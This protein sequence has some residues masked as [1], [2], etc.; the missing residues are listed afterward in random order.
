MLRQIAGVVIAVMGAVAL[1]PVM[2]LTRRTVLGYAYLGFWG[3]ITGVVLV[4]ILLTVTLAGVVSLSRGYRRLVKQRHDSSG[5]IG[6]V[7]E[8]A[9]RKRETAA[10]RLTAPPFA[11]VWRWLLV[12]GVLLWIVLF[13]APEPVSRLSVFEVSAVVAWLLVPVSVYFDAKTRSDDR[14]EVR[15]WTYVAGSLFP[16]V[17]AVAGGAYLVRSFLSVRERERAHSGG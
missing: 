13:V 15:V 12:V 8:S 10:Q 7:V 4:G 3:V 1:Y 5:R 17:A 16:F 11:R 14:E 9:E 6:S 2:I